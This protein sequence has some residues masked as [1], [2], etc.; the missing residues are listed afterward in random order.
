MLARVSSLRGVVPFHL[1]DTRIHVPVVQVRE[2]GCG[3]VE[4]TPCAAGAEVS[5]LGGGCLA[6]GR[7]GDNDVLALL[8]SHVPSLAVRRYG[9]RPEI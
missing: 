3:H 1:E 5:N 7:V 9:T 6:S 8:V 2:E 4:V